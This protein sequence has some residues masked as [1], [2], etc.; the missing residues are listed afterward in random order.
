MAKIDFLK[1]A[2][3]AARIADDKKG[4]DIV[5]L[6]VKR[7]TIVADYFLIVTVTSAPQMRAVLDAIDATVKQ[8]DGI[9]PLRREG[10]RGG[11]WAVLDYGGLV[12][13]VMTP[14]TRA[15]YALEKVWNEARRIS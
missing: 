14:E 7:L 11:T 5:I 2:R 3:K 15:F 4:S 6:N 1:L 9:D 8:E 10:T 12:V 13:H